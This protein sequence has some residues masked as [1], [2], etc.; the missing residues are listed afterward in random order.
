MSY[1][2]PSHAHA[3][4]GKPGSQ[5]WCS[6]KSNCLHSPCWPFAYESGFIPFLAQQGKPSTSS[7]LTTNTS[8]ISNLWQTGQ[9]RVTVKT[10]C[11]RV[12]LGKRRVELWGAA[13][14]HGLQRQVS[15]PLLLS[16]YCI[17]DLEKIP[18]PLFLHFWNG[19][20]FSFL[21]VVS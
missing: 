2:A 13:K 3:W 6:W 17:C 1:C 7:F 8:S 21:F 11:R 12:L 14:R 10:D 15:L 4:Y 5:G 16:F 19:E 18:L 9:K 20:F